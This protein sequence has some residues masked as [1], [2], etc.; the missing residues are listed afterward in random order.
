MIHKIEKSALQSRGPI[1]ILYPG[2]GISKEDSGLGSIGRIDHAK[3][4]GGG[5]IPMHP[6][7][8]DEI[9]SYFRTGKG[10]QRDSE[11]FEEVIGKEKLMLMKA[12]KYFEHEETM[13]AEDEALEGLQIFIRPGKKDLNPEVIFFDLDELHSEN[14]WRLLASPDSS[15]KFQ[16][17]SQTWLFDQKLLSGNDS[18]LPAQIQ[19]GQT[20]LLY[21]FEGQVRINDEILLDKK[22]SVIIQEESIQIHAVSDAELVLFVTDESAEIFKEG[23]YSGNQLN[24]NSK[25]R[26]RL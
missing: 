3:I 6:H 24:R 25:I 21:V 22:D 11:G 19:N 5:T 9:L 15:T 12:G 17:S 23:M 26:V 7:I 13:L 18:G 1:Q 20:L 10:I 16:F 8:N 4:V 14:Q 2:L